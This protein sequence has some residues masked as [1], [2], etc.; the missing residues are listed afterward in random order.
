MTKN[1]ISLVSISTDNNETVTVFQGDKGVWGDWVNL[2]AEGY[3]ACGATVRLQEKRGRT[4]DDTA[5]N[6][7]AL[8]FC[9]VN[10]W[11]Q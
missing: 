1:N 5:M 4:H 8:T 10:N 3:L 7:L 2:S 11:Y 6:G 9:Q